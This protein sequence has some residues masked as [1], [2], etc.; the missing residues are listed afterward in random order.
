[1]QSK[2]RET[3]IYTL[4]LTTQRHCNNMSSLV[5]WK[6]RR[7]I[8]GFLGPACGDHR[9]WWLRDELDDERH[10]VKYNDFGEEWRHADEWSPEDMCFIDVDAIEDFGDKARDFLRGQ[11]QSVSWYYSEPRAN[12]IE[13]LNALYLRALWALAKFE[14]DC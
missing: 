11:C 5:L 14:R 8:P 7:F 12:W 10:H 4:A 1:M 2:N 3:A 6:V 9:E 13:H